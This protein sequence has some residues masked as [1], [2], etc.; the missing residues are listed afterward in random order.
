MARWLILL[1][2]FLAWAG[3][4]LL[5]HREFSPKPLVA[6]ALANQQA[7][8]AL[9]SERAPRKERW[10][11]YLNPEQGATLKRAAELPS[12]LAPDWKSNHQALLA[13][14]EDAGASP[15]EI[16]VGVLQINL[17]SIGDTWIEQHTT[18]DMELPE[19]LAPVLAH[20]VGDRPLECRAKFNMDYGLMNF[21]LSL[22][23]GVGVEIE[24]IGSREGDKI[25]VALSMFEGAKKIFDQIM[26]LPVSGASM[27]VL[28]GSPFYFR[29]SIDAGARWNVALL[30]FSSDGAEP[31]LEPWEAQVMGKRAVQYHGS[32]RHVFEVLAQSGRKS[33][34]A[35]YSADG[36][37]LKQKWKFLDTI[38]ITLIREEEVAADGGAPFAPDRPLVPRGH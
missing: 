25:G 16:P 37:V 33:A 7:L 20:F 38:N 15:G 34:T 28:T 26:A 8:E 2:T 11:I 21:R 29:P 30:D 1:V 27:P 19:G 12:L 17:K 4:M 24:A 5:V 10:R 35:F 36:I 13:A 18:M 14:A 6:E 22:K 31:L 23:S 3:S 9:F 32:V